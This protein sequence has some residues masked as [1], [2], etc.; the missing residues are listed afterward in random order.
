M[1]IALVTHPDYAPQYRRGWR[2]PCG[3]EQFGFLFRY[4]IFMSALGHRNLQHP[5]EPFTLEEPA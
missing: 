1:I 5:G 3:A 4:D 2:C